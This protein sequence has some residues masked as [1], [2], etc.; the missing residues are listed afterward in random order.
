MYG[1]DEEFIIEFIRRLKF[2][3]Y[4]VSAEGNKENE[5]VE[6]YKSKRILINVYRFF[7]GLDSQI[8]GDLFSY[9]LN[10]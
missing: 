3:E 6:Y 8:N 4:L 1:R 2:Y 7:G 9:L 10:D 5:P